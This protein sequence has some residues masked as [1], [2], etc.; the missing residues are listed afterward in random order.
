MLDSLL[1]SAKVTEV[2]PSARRNASSPIAVTSAG[3]HASPVHVEP[4]VTVLFEMV[5]LPSMEQSKG[6]AELAGMGTNTNNKVVV[7][8]MA[9]ILFCN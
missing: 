9:K 3:I 7:I 6:C 8:A 4:F 5:K 2:N 1:P